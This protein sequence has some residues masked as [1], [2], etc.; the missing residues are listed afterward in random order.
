MV[1]V[2]RA[3]R[4]APRVLILDEP[5]IGL[6]PKIVLELLHRVRKLVDRGMSVLLVEQNIRASLEVADRLYLLERGRVVGSG[7]ADEMR[8]DSRIAEAYLGGLRR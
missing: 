3:L 2:A 4:A 8:G 7:T 1:A 6:A 5:S